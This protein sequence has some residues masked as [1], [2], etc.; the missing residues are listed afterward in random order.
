MKARYVIGTALAAT[1]L[2][3]VLGFA[4]TSRGD[5]TAATP[6]VA[7]TV[8]STPPAAADRPPSPMA[9]RRPLPTLRRFDPPPLPAEDP[10]I[11][12]IVNGPDEPAA[13]L[14]A[15][16]WQDIDRRLEELFG[17]LPADKRGAIKTAMTSW[18]RDHAR[19]VRAYYRGYI[20]QAELTDNIHANLL[21]YARAVEATLT[22]DQYRTFM[23][24]EPGEDPFIVLV[25]PGVT[26]GQP[27]T[28]GT[29]PHNHDT[30]GHGDD[31][32]PAE[33]YGN[34]E[35]KATP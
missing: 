13:D 11:A 31:H 34:P 14:V 17:K 1:G 20:D 32:G 12:D 35:N 9:G 24:L 4:T 27:L 5:A 6:V 21:S 23:D 15:A 29:D 22:R 19:V 16:R 2:A 3:F 30:G 7:A 33:D 26:V 25:P 18:I 28:P 8:T 10:G